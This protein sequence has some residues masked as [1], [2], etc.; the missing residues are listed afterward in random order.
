MTYGVVAR[1]QPLTGKIAKGY[2]DA[3]GTLNGLGH[4][5]PNAEFSPNL[6]QCVIT[7]AGGAAAKVLWAFRSGVVAVTTTQRATDFSRPCNAQWRRCTNEDAHVGPIEHAVWIQANGSSSRFF[8]TA[9]ND[10]YVKVWDADNLLK[11]PWTSPL[12]RKDGAVVIVRD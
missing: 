7:S 5:N 10:G 12:Q 2:L 11:S 8:A 3:S 1:S 6:T 4:G 9:G